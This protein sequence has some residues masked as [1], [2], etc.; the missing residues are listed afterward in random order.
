MTIEYLPQD[1]VIDL[2]KYLNILIAN[3]WWLIGA[4]LLFAVLGFGFATL[5]PSSYEATAIAAVTQAR[6]QLRFDPRIETISEPDV[7]YQTFA[8]LAVSDTVVKDLYDSLERLPRDVDSPQTLRK[9]LEARVQSDLVLLTVSTR[10]PELSELI[11]NQWVELFV[12]KANQIYSTQDQSQIQ[13]FDTQLADARQEL[14][15]ANTAM[16]EFQARNRELILN[17]QLKALQNSLAVFLENQQSSQVLLRDIRSLVS[18]FESQPADEP[19]TQSMQFSVLLLQNRAYSEVTLDGMTPANNLQVQL[20]NSLEGAPTVQNQVQQLEALENVIEEQLTNLNQQIS[21]LE[22]QITNT[23]RELQVALAEKDDLTRN[24]NVAQETYTTLARKVE[25]TRIASQDTSGAVRL[26][27][28]SLA[29]DEPAGIG[30]LIITAAAGAAGFFISVV[31]ILMI[32]WWRTPEETTALP[33]GQH[34]PA[35]GS[36]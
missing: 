2:R 11:A 28:Y 30:R 36:D 20:T 3:K 18:Q 17:D 6:N 10:D 29:N 26:A 24:L 9:R 35:P 23:Q 31:V 32:A 7:N 1:D 27:S 15:N 21:D 16:V 33:P 13:F 22:P 14:D 34:Q 12:L 19:A 4:T 25:E 8:T 5:L